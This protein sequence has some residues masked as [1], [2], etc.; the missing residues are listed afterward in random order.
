MPKKKIHVEKSVT[1]A[2]FEVGKIL[3]MNMTKE[4]GLVIKDDFQTRLKYFVIIGQT[5]DNGIVG[6]FLVNSKEDTKA[7]D[8]QFPLYEKDYPYILEYDSYLNCNIIFKLDK[9]KVY[10]EALEIGQLTEKDLNLVIHIIK[11]SDAIKITEKK[12]FGF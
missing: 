4:E 9:V 1:S 2:S 12:Q 3:K 6:V 10:N 8:Y 7:M 5:A 11:T